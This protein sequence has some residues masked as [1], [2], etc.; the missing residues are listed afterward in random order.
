MRFCSLTVVFVGSYLAG[1]L[2]CW[3]YSLRQFW[4]GLWFLNYMTWALAM[5]INFLKFKSGLSNRREK[6]SS[7]HG[8]SRRIGLRPFQHGMH[9]KYRNRPSH[10]LTQVV[11]FFYIGYA[12]PLALYKSIY[13]YYYYPIKGHF[14]G[15]GHLLVHCKSTNAGNCPASGR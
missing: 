3:K 6:S 2:D 9:M 4:G 12:P 8:C 7:L 5:S 11:Q 10:A 1:F 13:Y 15:G 14:F